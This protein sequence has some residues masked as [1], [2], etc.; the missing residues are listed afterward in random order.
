MGQRVVA[1]GSRDRFGVEGRIHD[2]DDEWVFGPFFLWCGGDRLGHPEDEVPLNGCR[3]WAADFGGTVERHTDQGLFDAQASVLGDLL[4]HPSTML[5][6]HRR[7]D[8]TYL[9]MCGL[10][11]HGDAVSLVLSERGAERLVW[12]LASQPPTQSPRSLLLESGTVASVVSMWVAAFDK[13]VG[14]LRG[15]GRQPQQEE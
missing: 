8:L 1:A 9:G 14:D 12:R 2:I 3:G 7:F 15:D 13:A 10:L 4:L 11:D 6:A 5:D